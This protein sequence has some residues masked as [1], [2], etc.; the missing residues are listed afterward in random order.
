MGVTTH[1]E[2]IFASDE[3]CTIPFLKM[4][5]TTSD[6]LNDILLKVPECMGLSDKLQDARQYSSNS[7]Q[8]SMTDLENKAQWLLILLGEYWKEYGDAIEPGYDWNQYREVT[9]FST[10]TE[11]WD[12]ASPTPVYFRTISAAKIIPEYDAGNL[13]LYS[14]LRGVY[15]DSVD[16]YKKKI[17]VHSAS[18]LESAA[19][20]GRVE[21]EAGGSAA[22]VFPLKTV[23]LCTPSL[24]QSDRVGMELAK[25]G[26]TRGLEGVCKIWKDSL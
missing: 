20:L 11:A 24:Q 1:K 6:R 13:I 26:K 5:K 19:F 21:A 3:W 22:M 2:T 12:F 14:I 18:I 23:H 10:N 25:W 17:A 7:A 8:H 4:K 16:D 9:N 15:W